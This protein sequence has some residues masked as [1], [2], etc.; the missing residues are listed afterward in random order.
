MSQT[1]KR[2]QNALVFLRLAH[3]IWRNTSLKSLLNS[4]KMSTLT[5]NSTNKAIH[6]KSHKTTQESQTNLIILKL[7]INYERNVMASE[8]RKFTVDILDMENNE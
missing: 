5:T 8:P 2:K 6:L 1:N 4:S 7:E 3:R